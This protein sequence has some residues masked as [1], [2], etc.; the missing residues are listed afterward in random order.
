MKGQSEREKQKN[1]AKE[2]MEILFHRAEGIF[3]KNPQ[4]ADRYIAIA[5]RIA[6]KMNLR[7]TKTQKRTFCKH[8]YSFLRSGVNA[9]IRTRDRKIITYCKICKKYTRIPI[10]EK[11]A[12]KRILVSTS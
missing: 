12:K 6:M 1:V 11:T 2:R 8:C 7:L 3:A 10:L 4:R 9:Q 5:R